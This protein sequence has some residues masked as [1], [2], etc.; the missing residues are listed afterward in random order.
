MEF[1]EPPSKAWRAARAVGLGVREMWYWATGYTLEKQMADQ[2]AELKRAKR[3]IERDTETAQRAALEGK[4]KCKVALKRG[5]GQEIAMQHAQSSV[6]AQRRQVMLMRATRDL[7]TIE[8]E[9]ARVRA[10][11]S[12]DVAM[13]KVT[14]LLER[15]RFKYGS[16]VEMQH[17][18]MSY[19]KEARLQL[20]NQ[21][22]RQETLESVADE[23]AD[24][25]DA[26]SSDD[27]KAQSMLEGFM[28]ELGL[29]QAA[30]MPSVQP[31]RKRYPPQTRMTDAE[32]D[33][34]LT[35]TAPPP[36]PPPRI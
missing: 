2:A 36:A 9:L 28:D 33:A 23:V 29:A 7:G 5:H 17:M 19:D 4:A 16:Q 14:E 11:M 27:A 35:N 1:G 32:V 18:L 6:A 34:F 13:R 15:F 30:Q 8:S 26:D 31:V 22:L 21:E 20:A 12:S 24:A 3:Q 10:D 25:A